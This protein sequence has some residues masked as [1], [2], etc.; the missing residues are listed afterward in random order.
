M[1]D[2]VAGGAL[3]ELSEGGSQFLTFALG[4]EEFGIDILRVQEIKGL[5]HLTHI[6]NMPVYIKGVMNLRGTVV[7]VV[8]LRSRFNM[9]AANYNQFTVIIVV[10]VGQKVMGLVVDAV[11]DVLN[12]SDADIE[13]LPDLGNG[14]DTTFVTGLAKSSER[15]IT[16]LDIEKLLGSPNANEMQLAGVR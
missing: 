13:P 3:A 9:S 4:D 7:P 8:D 15:L 14:I 1:H 12:V 6:P 11:S 5:T 16:L 2:N 10:T